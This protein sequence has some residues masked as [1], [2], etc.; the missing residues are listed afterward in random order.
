MLYLPKY[1]AAATREQYESENYEAFFLEDII[2]GEIEYMYLMI[3]KNK[4]DKNTVLV[5]SCE[6][7]DPVASMLSLGF[8]EGEF[9][10]EEEDMV[11][12]HF[13]CVFRGTKHENYGNK[14]DWT[15]PENFKYAALR[16][17]EEAIE[18]HLHV[19]I[20][21]PHTIRFS[22]QEKIVLYFYSKGNTTH[23]IA[24]KMRLARRTVDTHYKNIMKKLRIER[25]S[26]LLQV[27]IHMDFSD[28]FD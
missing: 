15:N 28:I 1:L 13:L 24:E 19:N 5:V 17:I 8:E 12:T 6:K 2:S 7:Y 20:K 25:R 14:E 11:E 18:E 10:L 26:T 22:R 16:L 9:E 3:A 4:H 27:A 23:E 21:Y